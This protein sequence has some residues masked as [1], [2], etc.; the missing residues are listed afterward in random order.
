MA[1]PAQ[2]KKSAGTKKGQKDK[3]AAGKEIT[4]TSSKQSTT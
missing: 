4:L 2:K 3:D 1:L